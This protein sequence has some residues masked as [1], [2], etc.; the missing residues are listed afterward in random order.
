MPQITENIR[1]ELTRLLPSS[2]LM[3]VTCFVFYDNHPRDQKLIDIIVGTSSGEIREYYKRDLVNSISLE[4]RYQPTDL[5]II[6][7]GNCEL[8]YLVVA[9]DELTIISRKEKPQIHRRILNVEKYGIEDAV[10]RGQGGL[11]VIIKDDAVPLVFD[12]NFVN[13]GDTAFVLNGLHA[14]ESLPILTELMRKLTQT[15]FSVKCNENTLK[16]FLSLRQASALSSY[17]KVHP[18]TEESVFNVNSSKVRD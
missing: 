3:E 18:N 14:D 11:K 16:E 9:G 6:R 5:K 7:N 12:D 15:K 2:L 13:L 10:C 1:P 17:Q 8:F 4:G